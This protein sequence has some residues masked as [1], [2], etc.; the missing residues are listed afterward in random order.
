M[1]E[2]SVDVYKIAP[3]LKDHF[4][5]FFH[6][7][8]LEYNLRT[9]N[10]MQKEKKKRKNGCRIEYAAPR[11]E[12]IRLNL[13]NFLSISYEPLVPAGNVEYTPYNDVAPQEGDVLLY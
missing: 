1:H 13:E 8:H 7:T 11:V 2:R 12:V 5:G 4:V 10:S 6:N 9:N 3:L